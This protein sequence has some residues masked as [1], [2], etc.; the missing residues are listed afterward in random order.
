MG[1]LGL[2][3]GLL[4]GPFLGQL[5]VFCGYSWDYSRLSRDASTNCTHFF[6]ADCSERCG[7]TFKTHVRTCF[8]ERATEDRR[9]QHGC[10]IR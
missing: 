3:L 9:R 7:A 6:R 2:L 4:L 8:C 1:P 10:L 5:W